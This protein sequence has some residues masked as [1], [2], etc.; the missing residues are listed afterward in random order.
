[1]VEG[2]RQECSYRCVYFLSLKFY[3]IIWKPNEEN[4]LYIPGLIDLV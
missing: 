2:D 3:V 1:M 4:Y